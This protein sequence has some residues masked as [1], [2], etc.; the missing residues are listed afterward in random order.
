MAF[1]TGS[2]GG[3]TC[4][5]MNPLLWIILQVAQLPQ[6]MFLP[7]QPFVWHPERIALV[8][9]AFLASYIVVRCYLPSVRSWPLLGPTLAWA[10]FV[11]W[12][13]QCKREQADIRIDLFL[14]YPFLVIVTFV[15]LLFILVGVRQKKSR[16][17]RAA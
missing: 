5:A 16:E 3:T 14:I 2:L 4:I 17:N 12:E 1:P 10:A 9:V 8:S 7:L 13:W 6:W 11:P 15:G